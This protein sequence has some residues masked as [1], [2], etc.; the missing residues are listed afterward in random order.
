MNRYKSFL[1][2]GTSRPVDLTKTLIMISFSKMTSITNFNITTKINLKLSTIP[3]IKVYPPKLHYLPISNKPSN[4]SIPIT[5]KN[6]ISLK[7]NNL[8]KISDSIISLAAKRLFKE[9]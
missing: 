9:K 6:S 4:K 1:L 3:D 7:K 5:F 2:T 8:H